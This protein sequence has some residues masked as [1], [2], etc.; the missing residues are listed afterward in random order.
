[1]PN[2]TPK[3]LE[4]LTVADFQQ[5]PVWR[6]RYERKKPEPIVE[7]VT[8]LPV[9]DLHGCIV[10][11]QLTLSGGK[12]IWARLSNVSTRD[13]VQNQ[14]LLQ[15]AF[16]KDGK[17][18][19]MGRYHEASWQTHGPHE[20]AAFFGE[21]IN[22]VFPIA[23]DLTPVAIGLADALHPTLTLEPKERLMHGKL[24]ELILK[25]MSSSIPRRRSA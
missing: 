7:P 13:A 24:L 5:H 20:L 15:A 17:W 14:H 12:K 4:D 22:D 21:H 9:D 1:M 3:Q 11:V 16:E 8:T 6:T 25:S 19:Q 23:I 18:F 2:E 10:G